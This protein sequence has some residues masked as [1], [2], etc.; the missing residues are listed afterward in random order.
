ML[1]ILTN[2]AHQGETSASDGTYRLIAALREL[3]NY[4]HHVEDAGVE[5]VPF[6]TAAA[7]C[8]LGVELFRRLVAELPL[9]TR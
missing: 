8:A 6:E 3:G 4:A 7:G 1:S 2:P 5:E 9:A